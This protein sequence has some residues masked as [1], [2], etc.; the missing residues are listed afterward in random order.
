MATKLTQT[1]ANPLRQLITTLPG[2]SSIP[3]YLLAMLTSSF[4]RMSPEE[5]RE[6]IA[7]IHRETGKILNGTA[8]AA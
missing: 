4:D 8:S 2:L 7:R 3:P 1:E 5:T 6:I